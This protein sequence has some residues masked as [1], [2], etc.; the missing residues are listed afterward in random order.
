[1]YLKHNKLTVSTIYEEISRENQ[2]AMFT[3]IIAVKTN[4]A[5]SRVQTLVLCYIKNGRT[6][7]HF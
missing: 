6:S 4:D 3:M 2:Q 5:S 7:E 1:M